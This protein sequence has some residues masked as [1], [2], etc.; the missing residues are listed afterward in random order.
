[1]LTS[2]NGIWKLRIFENFIKDVSLP[3]Y[4]NKKFTSNVI[5]L[6]DGGSGIV[7]GGFGNTAT[8]S[9]LIMQSQ[10][11]AM[12][13]N[14]I[15]VNEGDTEPF[16]GILVAEG[17]TADPDLLSLKEMLA[18]TNTRWQRLKLVCRYYYHV[19]VKKFSK[20]KKQ[21]INY[22]T[23]F[24][25]FNRIPFE[26]LSQTKEL[27]KYYEDALLHVEKT[28]QVALKDKLKDILSIVR[29]EITLI[30]RQM[31]KY[32]SEEQVIRLYQMV[33]ADQKLKLTW[34]KNFVKIIP[35]EV[36]KL[37]QKADE[38]EIFDNYVVLHFDPNNDATQLTEQEKRAAKDPIL[39]GV[40]EKSNKL[41]YIADWIDEY[42][43]LTL[44]NMFEK[45][46]DKVLE[47]NN[48]SVKSFIDNLQTTT[49]PIKL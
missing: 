28:G 30:D 41:Y 44:E 37:K 34:I 3:K 18:Y 29:A 10:L 20:K 22:T 38:L 26:N 7:T 15:P 32:V 8:S 24:N 2:V 25:F 45:L 17:I 27:I 36:L 9:Q 13:P 49:E 6:V 43:D 11:D 33:N 40:I 47:I 14:P 39:F 4:S 12:I 1:M 21:Q 48:V 46:Q 23:L 19:L 31:Q 35:T 16:R 42:C 5:G